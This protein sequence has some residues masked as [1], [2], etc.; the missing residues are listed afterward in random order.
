MVAILILFGAW[1]TSLKLSKN[2]NAEGIKSIKD[3]LSLKFT[4]LI[5]FV[6]VLVWVVNTLFGALFYK[7]EKSQDMGSSFNAINTLLQAHKYDSEDLTREIFKICRVN[8]FDVIIAGS[9]GSIRMSSVP[10]DLSQGQILEAFLDDNN[11]YKLADREKYTIKQQKDSRI[12][13]DFLILTGNLD[14]GDLIVIKCPLE[15]IDNSIFIT[16]RF[17]LYIGLITIILSMILS[18]AFAKRLTEPILELESISKRMAELDFEAKY[19][20]RKDKNEVDI[21]GEQMNSM[22]DSLQEAY[23]RLK[24]ANARLE[25]D[26]KLRDEMDNMRKEF[27]SNISH[28]LKTPIAIISGYAEGLNEG[29]ACD[30][31]TLRYYC[32]VI[33]DESKKMNDLVLDL[34]ELNKLEYFNE[35]ISKSPINLSELLEDVISSMKPI[36]EKDNIKLELSFI[37]GIEVLGDER[38]VEGVINNYLSNAMHFCKVP[39]VISVRVEE[40]ED[41]YRI[42][43]FNSGDNIDETKMEYIWDKF[44]KADEAR[45]RRYGGSG[46]GLSIVKASMEIMGNEYGVN[47]TPTGVE[48][49]FELDKLISEKY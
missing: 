7:I 30:E 37:N 22:S 31:E 4:G 44:Y 8:N 41:K 17:L 32:D 21:L 43:V 26:I 46:I 48:F 3:S 5:T 1:D 20:P 25:E 19:I 38:L 16:D 6:I 47:N 42:I 49:W 13:E 45:S 9:D 36:I 40:L 35:P 15:G 11:S 28:E 24:E 14:N 29:M 10:R 33:S 12:S 27:I 2:K 39:G 23:A 34:I 18:R